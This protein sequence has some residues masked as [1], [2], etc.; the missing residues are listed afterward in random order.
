MKYE[1]QELLDLYQLKVEEHWYTMFNPILAYV[2]NI[3][4][5][6]ILI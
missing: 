6:K 4:G 3:K 2:G 1:K 5:K